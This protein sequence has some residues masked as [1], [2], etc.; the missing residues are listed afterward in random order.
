MF[1]KVISVRRILVALQLGLCFTLCIACADEPSPT[2]TTS[3]SQTLSID[4]ACRNYELN[5]SHPGNWSVIS[6]PAWALPVKKTGSRDEKIELYVENNCRQQRS[7]NI[8]VKY[9]DG[10]VHTIPVV[11]SIADSVQSIQKRFAVG[12]G[13]DVRTY[14]D[15]RGVRSQIFN[16][17]KI[18]RYGELE[19]RKIYIDQVN[20]ATHLEIEEGN[21]IK[22]IAKNMSVEAGIEGNFHAFQ[23]ELNGAYGTKAAM[24]DNRYFVHMRQHYLQRDISLNN[25]SYE[26]AQTVI[27]EN[28]SPSLFTVD[29]A[30]QRQKVINADGSDESI[31][32]LFDMYGTHLIYKAELGGCYDYYYS[33]KNNNTL[34]ETTVSGIIK[35]NFA[36]KFKLDGAGQYNNKLDKAEFEKIEKF[37]VK[38]GNSLELATAIASGAPDASLFT[39]W[40]SSLK[41]IDKCDLL[42]YQTVPISILFPDH[43]ASKITNYINRLYYSEYPLTRKK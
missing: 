26:E 31:R 24:Q 10:Y 33:V 15:Q 43:I 9:Q 14:N 13:I 29:F 40:R 11:Q 2:S 6:S 34:D 36:Q 8:V 28:L 12:W 22:A 5:T 1:Q 30:N 20:T 23:L 19:N 42:S 25:L 7:G 3:P 18:K 38:G 17:L 4:G 16:A 27:L 32:E 41:D 37:Q 35:G 39:A 21:D